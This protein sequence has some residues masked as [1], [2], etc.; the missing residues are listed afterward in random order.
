MKRPAAT[1]SS[2]LSASLA[3]M[4]LL[5]VLSA[6]VGLA[7]RK[8]AQKQAAPE[9]PSSAGSQWLSIVVVRVKPDMLTEF[10]D[11]SK[12]EV[13]PGL[14]KIGVKDRTVWATGAFGDAFE[15]VF[16]T[17]INDWAQYDGPSLLLRAV[18]EEGARKARRLVA[19]VHTYAVQTRPDLSHIG[20]AIGPPKLALVNWLHIAPGRTAEFE[21]LLK[22][23]IVPAMKKADVRAYLVSRTVHGGDTNE[24]VSLTFMDSYADIGKEQPIVGGMGQA[25][26]NRFVPKTAGIITH[27]ERSIVR[28][29]PELSF[30][31]AANADNK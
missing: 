27:H 20:K 19:S 25:A 21:N 10:E 22:T 28:Y 14:K 29:V 1:L 15:Y 4:L 13:N 9:A 8:H 17:P 6:E 3:L 12:N 18:G 30:G 2:G 16:V 11:F 23:E 26:F 31:P 24:Y 5:L 7:Q